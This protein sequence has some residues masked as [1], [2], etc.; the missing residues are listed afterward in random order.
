MNIIYHFRVRGTGAEGVHIAGIVNGFRSL[1]HN[2]R[3]VSPTKTDPTKQSSETGN[4]VRAQ[5]TWY[6]SFLHKLAD[7]LPQPFFEL[8][9]TAYNFFAVPQLW[10]AI[11]KQKVDFIYERYAFYNLSGALIAS[12]MNIPLV[13]EVNELS[14]H[15]RIRGQYFVRMAQVIERYIFQRATVIITVSDFLKQEITK[16]TVS[17]NRIVTMPNGVP[18]KWMD[19]QPT[20]EEIIGLRERYGLGG[21]KVICFIGGLV[22]WHNF[23]LL[24]DVLHSVQKDFP[25]TVLLLVGEGPLND[26]IQRKA[27]SLGIKKESLLFVGSV[28]HHQVPLHISLADVTVIPETNSFRSPIKMFEYMALGKPVV[29]PRM[30]AIETVIDDRKDGI[31][32]TPGDNASFRSALLELLN[33][34][35]LARSVG[36]SAREKISL[37]FTWEMNA[38]KIINMLSPETR[39]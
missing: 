11:K 5:T 15:K 32:F 38:M 34:P 9:E 4:D 28:P 31:L 2:V 25:D 12:I 26:Y 27:E 7:S 18:K 24:L 22:Y 16:Q 14:G 37:N 21:K 3:L 17:E 36:E 19:N 10:L 8:M 20:N 29:A 1:G 13:V 23:D 35:S 33:A 30:P 39:H 6:S